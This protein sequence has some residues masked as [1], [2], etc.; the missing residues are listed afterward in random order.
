M[1]WGLSTLKRKT[2]VLCLF[3]FFLNNF[4]I[5]MV[6]NPTQILE[7]VPPA[8]PR[9]PKLQHSIWKKEWNEIDYFG[10]FLPFPCLG[11]LMMGI[12][13]SFHCLEVYIEWNGQ[14]GTLISLY[15]LKTSNFHSPQNQEESQGMKFNLMKF[16]LKLPKHPYIFNLLI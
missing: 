2:E 6:R 7:P 1:K 15:S 14:K 8:L 11:V 13:R 9:T 16:L 5:I 12:E 4:F 3:F 10:I